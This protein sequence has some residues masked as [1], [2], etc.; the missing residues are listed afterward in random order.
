MEVCTPAERH[1]AMTRAQ[2]LKRAFNIDIETC[3]RCGGSVRAIAS[4]EDPDRI[5]DHLRRSERETS[6]R[7]LLVEWR[8]PCRRHGVVCLLMCHPLF[9]DTKEMTQNFEHYLGDRWMP[10]MH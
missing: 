6:T 10:P 2:R 4:I 3:G 1:A 7:Q 8:P 5:L 9:V